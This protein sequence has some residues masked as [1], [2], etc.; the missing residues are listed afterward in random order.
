[1][2]RK[3]GKLSTDEEQFI[4]NSVGRLSIH[5]IAVEINRTDETVQRFCDNNNLTYKGMSEE[6]YDDT[7]LQDKLQA[8]PYWGEVTQQFTDDELVYFAITWVRVIKQF[9]EDILYSEEL[10]VKQW[11]TQEIMGN[12][13]LRERK[14]AI[15][16][17]D[18]L[19][20]LLDAEY[21]H[22]IEQRDPEM[23]AGLET[24]LSHVRNGLSSYTTEHTK[25]LGN[26]KDIQK[27]LKAAR[28]DRVK[29]VED[30]KSSFSGFIRALEDEALRA[31]VG[32]DAAIMR[33]AMDKAEE[34]LSANHKYED[35]LVDQPFLIPETARDD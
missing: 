28:A 32:E 5:D 16:Q 17:V 34:R 3:R 14:R 8:R 35:G 9:Q 2:A 7:V 11:I 10:Q 6:K 31:R 1:M 27:D 12:R 13:V 33:L 19:Q 25:I 30:S 23:I 24:E 20:N 4:R 15:E 22:P 18:R 29:K 26:I 21:A